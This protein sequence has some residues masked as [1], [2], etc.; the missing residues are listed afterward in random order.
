MQQIINKDLT[1]SHKIIAEYTNNQQKSIRNIINRYFLDFE[2]LGKVHFKNASIQNSKNKVNEIVTY[3]LNEQQ[4]YLLLTYLRN[5]EIVRNFKITLVKAFFE[6]REKL[7]QNKIE[8]HK[9]LNYVINGYKSQLSQQNQ[10]IKLLEEQLK[11]ENTNPFKGFYSLDFEF[12]KRENEFAYTRMDWMLLLNECE[13]T[14][15]SERKSR[16]YKQLLLN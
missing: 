6:M 4:A 14:L 11:K 16:K 1:I 3:Y 12:S 8:N 13:Q 9:N 7:Y 5:N 10:K 15:V 2:G